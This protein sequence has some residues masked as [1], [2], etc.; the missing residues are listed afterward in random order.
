ML[1][2][3]KYYEERNRMRW[4]E[5]GILNKKEAAILNMMTKAGI[6]EKVAIWTTVFRD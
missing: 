4:R 3:V 2:D 6:T 5:I 1:E